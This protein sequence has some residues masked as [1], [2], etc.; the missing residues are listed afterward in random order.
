M[1][2]PRVLFL[3]YEVRAWKEKSIYNKYVKSVISVHAARKA[4]SSHAKV[5]NHRKR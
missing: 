4:V 3:R 2:F 1:K 5:R